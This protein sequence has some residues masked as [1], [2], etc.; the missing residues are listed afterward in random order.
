MCDGV[1]IE[2][3]TS[4]LHLDMFLEFWNKITENSGIGK[5]SFFCCLFFFLCRVVAALTCRFRMR[6]GTICRLTLR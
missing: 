4:V 6:F 5:L 1:E 3:G 2:A